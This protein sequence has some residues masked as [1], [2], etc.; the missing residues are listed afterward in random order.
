LTPEQEDALMGYTV[1]LRS[2]ARRAWY[3]CGPAGVAP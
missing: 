1:A 2:Y 3:T